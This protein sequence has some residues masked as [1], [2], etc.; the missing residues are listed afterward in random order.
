MTDRR[1]ALVALPDRIDTAKRHY[2]VYGRRSSD[3]SIL[4]RDFPIVGGAW[5]QA[6]RDALRYIGWLRGMGF[7]EISTEFHLV[8]TVDL[9]ALIHQEDQP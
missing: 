4:A 1:A 8:E 5:R 3:F 2:H 7:D 9:A 6:A